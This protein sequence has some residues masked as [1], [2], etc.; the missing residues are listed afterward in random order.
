M[1]DFLVVAWVIFLVIRQMSRMKR[2]AE[3]PVRAPSTKECPY[4]MSIIAVKAVRCAHCTSELS[5]A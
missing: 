2:P 3:A 4:C 1:I 5:A